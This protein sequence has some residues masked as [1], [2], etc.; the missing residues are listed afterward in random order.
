MWLGVGGGIVTVARGSPTY[1]L[2][3][4]LNRRV[5]QR[6]LTIELTQ[7]ILDLL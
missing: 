5:L 4:D 1:T 7:D 3:L 2:P 6:Q